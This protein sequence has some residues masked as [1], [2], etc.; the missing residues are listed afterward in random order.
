MLLH[1]DDKYNSQIRKI[2]YDELFKQ[3]ELYFKNK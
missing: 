1:F 2:R 3:A